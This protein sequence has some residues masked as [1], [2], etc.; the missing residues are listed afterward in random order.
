MATAAA[1]PLARSACRRAASVLE[2]IA[3]GA[4]LAR[5]MLLDRRGDHALLRRARALRAVRSR[6]TSSTSTRRTAGGSRSSDAPSRDHCGTT[7]QSTDVLARV[8]WGAQTELEVVALVARSSRSSIGVPLGLI[9]GYFGG[10][11]TAGSS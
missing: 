11:S 10:S 5:V 9:S 4:R 1:A 3:R 7:V 6:R 2:P 8:I